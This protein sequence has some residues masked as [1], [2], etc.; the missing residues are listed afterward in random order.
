MPWWY[1]GGTMVVQ[2]WYNVGTMVVQWWCHGGD[3][4]GEQGGRKRLSW[5]NIKTKDLFLSSQSFLAES[6]M[7]SQNRSGSLHGKRQKEFL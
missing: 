4:G 1:N 2:W 6:N 7:K 5:E 3:G